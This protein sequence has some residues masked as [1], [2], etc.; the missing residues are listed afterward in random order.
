MGIMGE[1]DN[2]RRVV[3]SLFASYV[4]LKTQKQQCRPVSVGIIES[5]KDPSLGRAVDFCLHC[6]GF[7]RDFLALYGLVSMALCLGFDLDYL[8]VDFVG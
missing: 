5:V 7:G 8:S 3:C 6:R 1:A 2:I 4:A